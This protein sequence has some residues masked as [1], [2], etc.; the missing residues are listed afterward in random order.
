MGRLESALKRSSGGRGWLKFR[1]PAMQTE[2]PKQMPAEATPKPRKRKASADSAPKKMR[3]KHI[4]KVAQIKKE[5]NGHV[6]NLAKTVNLDWHDSYEQTDEELRKRFEALD[7]RS[8]RWGK[9]NF[10][11]KWCGNPKQD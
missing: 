11:G 8:G 10:F 4:I 1:C 6:K 9:V 3:V 2:E 7:G 5:L